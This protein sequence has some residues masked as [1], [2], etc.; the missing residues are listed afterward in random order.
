[1][2]HHIIGVVVG[3]AVAWL[4][5]VITNATTSPQYI[6]ALVIGG[7]VSILW[8]I[9]IVWWLARR[10]KARRDADISKEVEA[11]IKARGG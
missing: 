7:I 11:Q 8:P 10:A 3:A 4:T 2:L 9:V 6:T 1:M 5:L